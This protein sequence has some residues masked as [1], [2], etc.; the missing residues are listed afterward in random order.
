MTWFYVGTKIE[1]GINFVCSTAEGLY[2]MWPAHQ[3]PLT[4]TSDLKI[5]SSSTEALR[6]GNTVYLDRDIVFVCCHSFTFL[7]NTS[8]RL[9][10]TVRSSGCV[11]LVQL[12]LNSHSWIWCAL[13]KSAI[14]WEIWGPALSMKRMIGLVIWCLS[15]YLMRSSRM[16]RKVL[17]VMKSFRVDDQ[18]HDPD[19]PSL[20]RP[21]RCLA[22]ILYTP[23]RKHCC[24]A[25]SRAAFTDRATVMWSLVEDITFRI[26]HCR[27]L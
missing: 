20:D 10:I 15:T 2:G 27:G 18:P 1:Q 21:S 5:I 26:L 7:L 23:Q 19:F 13:Q 11:M 8:F 9:F 22:A 17:L 24:G 14:A 16:R 4:I 25:I 12:G 6:R 3:R